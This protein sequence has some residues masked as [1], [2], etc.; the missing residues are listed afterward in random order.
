MGGITFGGNTPA[1]FSEKRR[2]DSVIFDDQLGLPLRPSFIKTSFY[3]GANK[4]ETISMNHIFDVDKYKI[5]KGSFNNKYYYISSIVTEPGE[6]GTI[7]IN[8]SGKEQ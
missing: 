8:I 3:I 5:N 1:N 6:T 2:S 4:T 7:Q